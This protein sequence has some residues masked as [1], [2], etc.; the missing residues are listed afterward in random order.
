MNKLLG[1]IFIF[2]TLQL[3]AQNFEEGVTSYRSEN[4]SEA[5]RIW[6]NLEDQGVKDKNLFLN[7]GNAFFKLKDYPNAIYY[8]NKSIYLCPSCKDAAVNLAIANRSA[9]IDEFE[10]PGYS[11]QKNITA[12]YTSL[13]SINFLILYLISMLLAFLIWKKSKAHFKSI[14]IGIF[15]LGGFIFLGAFVAQEQFKKAEGK[16]ILMKE[17]DLLQSP[18]ELSEGKTHLIAGEK[19]KIIDQLGSWSKIQSQSY[20]VGWIPTENLRKL[21]PAK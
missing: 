11:F 18:D 21:S 16:G 19:I 9:K 12:F 17:I 7:L 2:Y 10:I 4:Y 5:I 20:E 15:L 6:K 1:L 14:W 13:A 8:Y 3:N